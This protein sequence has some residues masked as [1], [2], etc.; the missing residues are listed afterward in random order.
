MKQEWLQLAE[1]GCFKLKE[2]QEWSVVKARAN[3]EGFKVH[4][5]RVFGICVDKGSELPKDDKG[6]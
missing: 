6:R 3:K 5:G 4:V 1:K 2:V